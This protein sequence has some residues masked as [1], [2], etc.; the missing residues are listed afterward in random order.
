MYVCTLAATDIQC[1]FVSRRTFHYT[2]ATPNYSTTTSPPEQGSHSILIRPN[3]VAC[4]ITSALQASLDTQR[5]RFVQMPQLLAIEVR[6]QEQRLAPG[7]S[8]VPLQ[9]EP[10]IYL[11]RFLASR[12]QDVDAAHK[13]ES[14]QVQKLQ[15][16]IAAIERRRQS[17]TTQNGTPVVETLKQSI[18]YFDQLCKPGDDPIRAE[19]Q[20]EAASQLKKILVAI[21]SEGAGE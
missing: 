11:D 3:D 13:S 9:L 15:N 10:V 20:A 6:P 4:T 16:L 8:Y 14:G 21:E 12:S 7:Q 1:S 18:E 19:S 5:A 17:I 2:I